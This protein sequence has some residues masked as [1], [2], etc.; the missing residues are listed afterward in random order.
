MD[1]CIFCEIA[2]GRIDADLTVFEND[3]IFVQMCLAQK[4]DNQGHVL[5]MPKQHVKDIYKLPPELD[6]PLLVGIRLAANA[7]KETFKADGVNIRQ[8]NEASAGQDVFHLHFHI[9][10]RFENDTFETAHYEIIDRDIRLQLTQ[11]LKEVFPK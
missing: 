7:V 3:Q 4:A 9:I 6:A 10:P 2:A 11:R 5:V 8:N 1:K